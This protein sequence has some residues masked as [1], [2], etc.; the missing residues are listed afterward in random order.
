MVG[1]RHVKAPL[2]PRHTTSQNVDT[3]QHSA[4]RAR[5]WEASHEVVLSDMCSWATGANFKYCLSIQTWTWAKTLGRLLWCF[6]LGTCSVLGLMIQ[7]KHT[8][9]RTLLPEMLLVASWLR[10][11]AKDREGAIWRSVWWN[12]LLAAFSLAGSTYS[13]PHA[14]NTREKRKHVRI[15]VLVSNM[16]VSYVKPIHWSRNYFRR[17]EYVFLTRMNMLQEQPALVKRGV[18]I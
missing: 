8:L 18:F 5:Q 10:H 12:V 14:S 7:A 4:A 2:H 3:S 13:E 17:R 6:V 1:E 16:L 11:F 15:Y 9:G